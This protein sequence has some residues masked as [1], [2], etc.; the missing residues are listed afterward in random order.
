MLKGCG[1][2]NQIVLCVVMYMACLPQVLLLLNGVLVLNGRCVFG[3]VKMK[4][5]V[6]LLKKVGFNMKQYMVIE[7]E[8]HQVLFEG[9]YGDCKMWVMAN[10]HQVGY[11]RVVQYK[12][13]KPSFYRALV[14]FRNGK[15]V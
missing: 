4:C 2:W 9:C 3:V 6:N 14:N 13:L 1:L 7:E 12:D 11:V 5:L 15:K 8:H 10:K